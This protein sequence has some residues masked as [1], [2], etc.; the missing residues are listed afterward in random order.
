MANKKLKSLSLCSIFPL[1]RVVAVNSVVLRSVP[2]THNLAPSLRKG[3]EIV[4]GGTNGRSSMQRGE[5]WM[6]PVS[7]V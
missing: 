1:T 2:G 7:D 4:E 3:E 5:H 6:Q